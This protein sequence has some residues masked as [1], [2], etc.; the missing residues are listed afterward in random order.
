M[1]VFIPYNTPSSKNSRVW[2]GRFFVTSKATTK[3][4]NDTKEY[5]LK[6]AKEF[7]NKF[8]SLEKPVKIYFQFIRKS[9]HRFDYHNIS[10]A[11][12]DMMVEY[13]WIEDDNADMI[14]PVFKPYK[15]DKNNSG[16]WIEIK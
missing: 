15:Y 11:P 4:K 13:G 10:Q 1:K 12:C 7:R 9:K 14:I 8:D 3:W 16:V 2:T 5:W 6:H